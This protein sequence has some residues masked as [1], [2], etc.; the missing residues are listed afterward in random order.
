MSMGRARLVGRVLAVSRPSGSSTGF[1][2]V[3]LLVVIAVIAIL[4]AILLP[5]VQGAREASR[6][7]QCRNGLKQLGLAIQ[8]YESAFKRFPPGAVR[9]SFTTGDR[10]RM[11]FVAQI[12]P[13]IEQSA[14]YN[15]ID[16][17]KSWHQSPNSSLLVKQ[18]PIYLCP[19]DPTSGGQLTNPSEAYGNFGLNWGMNRYLD[20]DGNG[21]TSNEPGG[22]VPMCSPFGLNYGAKFSRITDGT[23]HTLAM[24][25]MLKG[26]GAG[27][28]DR[29]GRIWNDDSNCYQ[30][31][32]RTTPNSK[33]PDY[34]ETGTC[35]DTPKRNLPYTLAP[36][37]TATGRGQSAIAARSAHAGG[38]HV[39]MCDGAV[40]FAGDGV[41]LR[42]WQALSTE[43]NN[44]LVGEW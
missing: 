25:E 24:L 15:Q 38:V 19:S 33:E 30:I 42:T 21:S 43:R 12:L 5:A 13:Y 44:D 2:T 3:E 26:I 6:R 32:T 34:C 37:A 20:L 22:S 4:V 10:Y 28:V 36:E 23:S 1:T 35:V 9:V 11:P 16:F 40:R 29:R 14:L 31:S 7:T 39:L 17:S 41:D 8:N 18:V 27:G